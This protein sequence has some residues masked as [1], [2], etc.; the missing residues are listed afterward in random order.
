M[1]TLYEVA[2]MEES[3]RFFKD[4]DSLDKVEY[5]MLNCPGEVVTIVDLD[6]A[7]LCEYV[8]ILGVKRVNN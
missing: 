7:T 8:D 4:D 2:C 3:Y 5:A 1:I 6:D